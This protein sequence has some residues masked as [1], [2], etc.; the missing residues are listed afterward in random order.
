MSQTVWSSLLM[1]FSIWLLFLFS[2]IGVYPA[3]SDLVF[4]VLPKDGIGILNSSLML[5]CNAF[6][7]I[8]KSLVP[9]TWEKNNGLQDVFFHPQSLRA[10]EGRDVFLQCVSGD[11]SP[12]AQISWTKNGRILT[13]GNLI[14]GQYG[15]G[16]QKKTSG[17]LHMANVSKADQG[18]YIC[19]TYNPLLNTSK[20]SHA[21]TLT[22]K[23]L[24]EDEGLYLCE[25][26]NGKEKV[27]SESAYLRPA[28][29]DWFFTLEPGNRTAREGESL[30]LPCRSPNSS[31]QTQVSWYK[32]SRPLQ[33]APHYT[34]DPSGQLLFHSLQETDRGVY[35]CRVSNI[36]LKRMVSSQKIVLDV[37][38]PPSVTIW[39]VLVKS[40]VG[41]EVVIHCQVSGHPAPFMRWSKQGRSVQTGGKIITGL[42]NTTLHISSVRVYDEGLYT[43][44]A[45]NQLGHD[46]KT[47]TLRVVADSDVS[48]LSKQI[49]H[50]VPKSAQE[51]FTDSIL[52][53]SKLLTN[54]EKNKNL[55]QPTEKT[56]MSRSIAF[57]DEPPD[58]LNNDSLSKHTELLSLNPY[59]ISENEN[60][61]E[62]L[63]IQTSSIV[64]DNTTA[65]SQ[66]TFLQDT[67]PTMGQVTKPPVMNPVTKDLSNNTQVKTSRIST[68]GGQFF[69][70][71]TQTTDLTKL[72]DVENVTHAIPEGQHQNLSQPMTNNTELVETPRKNTS[73]APMRTTDSKNREKEKSQT[74]FPVIEKHDIPIVVGVGV[75]LAF[76]FIT[77]AFYSLVQKNDPVAIPTGR[78]ALRSVGGPCRQGERLPMERTYDNKAFEDDNCMAVIEQ[79]PNTSDTRAVPSENIQSLLIMM[80]PA[81]DDVSN[82]VQSPQ[83]LPVTVETHPEPREEDQCMEDWKSRVS[84][85]CQDLP[86]PV[87]AQEEALR[88]SLSLQTP[89]PPTGPVRHSISISHG[90]APLLL[91]HSVTLGSTSVAVD[92]HL[93]PSSTPSAAAMPHLTGPVFGAPGQNPN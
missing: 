35:S 34:V 63:E 32:N 88:S 15:G 18:S 81:P 27:T 69:E 59:S 76:I 16:S 5:H 87:S 50:A 54:K 82:G 90:Q 31:S 68:N 3:G 79:S 67:Q 20:E 11:S 57:K 13:K 1:P 2:S 25:A 91:S 84:E 47:V 7:S 89:E 24:L 38:A 21:A 9:V 36:F 39:P 93:Y 30:T 85:P 92:V 22:V 48:P 45:S 78:A 12:P 17:T 65:F 61:N 80:E 75:S 37:L 26:H 14:Q 23:V 46:E 86:S 42:K 51:G 28:E 4:S 60:N 73:Q 56:W 72:M 55:Q 71:Q 40:L 70:S 6:D 52:H 29:T 77:M 74:W 10:E 19:V 64:P 62:L 33:K 44:F 49:K 53:G 58:V 83:E 66:H 43:C 8:Q 41:S